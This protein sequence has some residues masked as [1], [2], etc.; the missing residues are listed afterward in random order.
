MAGRHLIARYNDFFFWRWVMSLKKAL[1]RILFVFFSLLVVL[2]AVRAVWNVGAGA[3]LA[4]YLK[5]AE[6]DGVPLK[7]A[8][9]GPK[10]PAGESAAPLWTAADAL[11]DLESVRAANLGGSPFAE[12][13]NGAEENEKVRAAYEASIAKNRRPIDLYLESSG[14]TCGREPE[15]KSANDYAQ[16]GIKRLWAARLIG[17][18]AVSKAR[19]GDAAGGLDE[20]LKGMKAVRLSLDEPIL[21]NTLISIASMKYFV[22]CVDR[23]VDG[24]A[25]D[26]ERLRPIFGVLSSEEWY[27]M[28]KRHVEAERVFSLETWEAAL[29]NGKAVPWLFRPLLRSRFVRYLKSFDEMERIYALPRAERA[30]AVLGFDRRAEHPGWP[31]RLGARILPEDVRPGDPTMGATTLKEATLEALMDTARIGLAARIF[32]AREGRWPES[33]AALVPEFLETKPLDPFTGKPYVYR[34]GEPG[35]LVYSVGANLKDEDGRGT[36]QI[37][38][39]VMPKDDDWAWRDSYK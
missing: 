25:I 26:P 10:C 36:Y 28:F 34:A 17:V 6:A 21:I 11:L 8:D 18:E 33:L 19:K 32:K 39:L 24:N 9:L 20:C 2:L 13:L 15:R 1:S 23:I 3:S 16:E 38:Q 29:K 37:T 14:R 31:G 12:W 4:R 7:Y 22:V 35:L 27:E 5:R 30:S